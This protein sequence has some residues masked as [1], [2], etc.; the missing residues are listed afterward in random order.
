MIVHSEDDWASSLWFDAASGKVNECQ[1]CQNIKGNI[2]NLS[3]HAEMQL[4]QY[5]HIY[6]IWPGGKHTAN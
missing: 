5:M 6:W 1:D 3:M 4:C 2:F